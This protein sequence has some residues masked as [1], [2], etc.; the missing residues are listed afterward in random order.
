MLFWV[1][2]NVAKARL[3]GLMAKGLLCALTDT[4]GVDASPR[5]VG[6]APAAGVRG[7]VHPL[8]RA[9]LRVALALVLPGT[10]AALQAGDTAPEPEWGLAHRLLHRPL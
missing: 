7:F 4:G 6:A 9:G 1:P 10:A 8:P 2:S 3:K 5:R